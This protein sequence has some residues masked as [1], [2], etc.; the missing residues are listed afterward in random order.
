MIPTEVV[1]FGDRTSM[2]FTTPK[3]VDAAGNVPLAKV[4]AGC[5]WAL[6]SGFRQRHVPTPRRLLTD[7]VDD[8]ATLDIL[9]RIATGDDAVARHLQSSDRLQTG[10]HINAS[11]SMDIIV[12]DVPAMLT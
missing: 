4:T 6:T 3:P 5:L 9:D 12:S 10:P 2:F 1:A 8:G 7:K 11:T